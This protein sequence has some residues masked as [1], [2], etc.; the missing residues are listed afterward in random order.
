MR[1]VFQ[2]F[3]E[4]GLKLRHKNCFFGLQEMEYLDYIVSA[5]KILVP[6]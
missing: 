1:F 3:E 6:T 5:R 4:E 2:R